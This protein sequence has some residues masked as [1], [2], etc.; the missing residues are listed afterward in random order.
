MNKAIDRLKQK[1]EQDP[2]Q[3]ILVG[4]IA[5]TAVAKLMDARSN[6]AGRRTWERE[7]DRRVMNSR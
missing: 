3:C 1:W 4:A 7:V 2:L 6:A 5:I